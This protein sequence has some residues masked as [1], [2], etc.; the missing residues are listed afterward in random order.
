[1]EQPNIF[2]LLI[3]R[4][5]QIYFCYSEMAGPFPCVSNPFLFPVSLFLV[6]V[7]LSLKNTKWKIPRVNSFKLRTVLSSAVELY[8]FLICE[9]Y[10][11]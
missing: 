6:S 8:A 2:N 5:L 1:M 7:S 11:V 10:L 9:P 4:I 3:V